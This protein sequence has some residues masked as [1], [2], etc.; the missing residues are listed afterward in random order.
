MAGPLNEV[1]D[2]DPI[3]PLNHNE[4]DWIYIGGYIGNTEKQSPEGETSEHE[5]VEGHVDTSSDAIEY[6]PLSENQ[7]NDLGEGAEVDAPNYTNAQPKYTQ[8][9][10]KDI[11]D[12]NSIEP[13]VSRPN[14]NNSR[15][16][17]FDFGRWVAKEKRTHEMVYR[18][19]FNYFHGALSD[20]ED[21]DFE[22]QDDSPSQDHHAP[23]ESYPED[24]NDFEQRELSLLN[25]NYD[26][27]T[28]YY[29]RATEHTSEADKSRNATNYYGDFN[30]YNFRSYTSR[31]P[32]LVSDGESES[33]SDT[34]SESSESSGESI[35][36]DIPSDDESIAEM[37]VKRLNNPIAASR[38]VNEESLEDSFPDSL[39]DMLGIDDLHTGHGSSLHRA[40]AKEQHNGGIDYMAPRE[41]KKHTRTG[42]YNSGGA[43]RGR[44]QLKLTDVVKELGSRA[45]LALR[46]AA[47]TAKNRSKGRQVEADNPLKKY[48]AGHNPEG[49]KVLDKWKRGSLKLDQ[50]SVRHSFPTKTKR[51][52][53]DNG[54]S[55][56]SDLTKLQKLFEPSNARR[57]GKKSSTKKRK[58]R[59][60]NPGIPP[61]K[62]NTTVLER[63]LVSRP[64]DDT[65]NKRTVKSKLPD[66]SGAVRKPNTSK[67]SKQ[68]SHHDLSASDTHDGKIYNHH[69]SSNKLV[70]KVK[71]DSPSRYFNPNLIPRS[72]FVGSGIVRL[73]D[74]PEIWEYAPMIGFGTPLNQANE[75]EI[76]SDAD[77]ILELC[78]S[79]SQTIN[80]FKMLYVYFLQ[81]TAFLCD[82]SQIVETKFRKFVLH[83]WMKLSRR[84]LRNY[85]ASPK[86]MKAQEPVLLIIE[87]VTLA[88]LVVSRRVMTLDPH[89]RNGEKVHHL[90]IWVVYYLQD[91]IA[92]Q[93]DLVHYNNMGDIVGV[94]L[95]YLVSK[96]GIFDQ[97]I[98][99]V[100]SKG[101]DGVEQVSANWHL[102]LLATAVQPPGKWDMWKLN[103]LIMGSDAKS[104]HVSMSYAQVLISKW[105]WPGNVDALIDY[106]NFHTRRDNATDP[107]GEQI[108]LPSF[109]ARSRFDGSN[110]PSN[111]FSLFLELL[112]L[113]LR[114]FKEDILACRRIRGRVTPLSALSFPDTNIVSKDDLSNATNQYGILIVLY[115]F[116]P[117]TL[118]PSIKQIRD[119]VVLKNSHLVIRIKAVS[120][121]EIISYYIESEAEVMDCFNWMNKDILQQSGYPPEPVPGP[122]LEVALRVSYRVKPRDIVP[123]ETLIS[124]GM[125]SF[126][127]S[128]RSQ[129]FKLASLYSS[130]SSILDRVME[131][132]DYYSEADTNMFARVILQFPE[133]FYSKT[134]KFLLRFDNPQEFDNA[135]TSRHLTIIMGISANIISLKFSEFTQRPL[136]PC[137]VMIL[138]EAL[139][140]PKL[141]NEGMK[142]LKACRLIENSATQRITACRKFF[143]PEN[144]PGKEI[145]VHGL[146]V[147]SSYM[148]QLT[149]DIQKSEYLPIIVTFR[150]H[151]FAQ[152]PD[153]SRLYAFE[154]N[155]SVRSLE[156]M[157]RNVADLAAI[158]CELG[159]DAEIPEAELAFK[160][161]KSQP[162]LYYFAY[163]LHDMIE[164]AILHSKNSEII[165]NDEQ[166]IQ[167]IVETVDNVS[168][169]TGEDAYNALVNYAFSAIFLLAYH[170]PLLGLMAVLP[171]LLKATKALVLRY[172]VTPR[173]Q[174]LPFL[175][176]V[177]EFIAKHVK[178]PTH[179]GWDLQV[180]YQV[181]IFGEF[182]D[183]VSIVTPEIAIYASDDGEVPQTHFICVAETYES[184]AMLETTTYQSE[185]I[186]LFAQFTGKSTSK[187]AE[188]LAG[189]LYDVLRMF[190]SAS[191][192]IIAELENPKIENPRKIE[193]ILK[194][195][196][197]KAKLMGQAFIS[198]YSN[199]KAVEFMS[200]FDQ[201]KPLRYRH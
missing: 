52:R 79:S 174:C 72:T 68:S 76:T 132:H 198:R 97:L 61:S 106:F 89:S 180:Q 69:S 144:I 159:L 122:L 140:M 5:R 53:P 165:I 96:F 21:E 113:N 192:R 105:N 172:S 163:K 195:K 66:Y 161:E 62:F 146:K 171:T 59:R 107:R 117:K 73:L 134:E 121:W 182:C 186:P 99:Q 32:Q 58:K 138:M 181:S 173:A 86:N 11:V 149:S 137:L 39:P 118:R 102:L 104:V 190:S 56:T 84:L 74:A 114:F 123:A 92:R 46:V 18:R 14:D 19:K 85:L 179:G 112:G 154:V 42:K 115:R 28:D 164:T 178:I 25:D 4:G 13:L 103:R 71:K 160:S 101:T 130:S 90:A 23:Q 183:I 126:D 87:L 60:Y 22:E 91:H 191:R 67:L 29:N 158:I 30:G 6:P 8:E 64:Y 31:R 147:I 78:Q 169:R 119:L 109:L 88:A 152:Y 116:L 65:S 124:L 82:E 98:E 110:R 128:I 43:A 93:I 26:E 194:Y 16:R 176:L 125:G 120:A 54:L 20:S 75:V 139:L 48:F 136:H 189:Y 9:N 197:K 2:S 63:P 17:R 148:A 157:Q 108:W 193:V 200:R 141:S 156:N 155:S 145:W 51:I 33:E 196:A 94:E 170:E 77:Q 38:N 57:S 83:T 151:A 49:N 129:A 27:N 187:R 36:S 175:S 133:L 41:R 142:L 131:V 153:L 150:K 177:S 45:P 1:F 199:P 70:V 168:T 188:S 80:A 3:Y 95:A 24:T 34:L 201:W 37:F 127:Q 44:R 15:R 10:V 7:H 40:E 55:R 81:S 111:S 100:I 35:D 135:T 184:T 162:C 166:F 143:M 185:F 50:P 167:E 12:S 47:R